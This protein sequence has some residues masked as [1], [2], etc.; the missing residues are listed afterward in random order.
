[1]LRLAVAVLLASPPPPPPPG[2][3]PPSV[4][5]EERSA[6]ASAPQPLQQGA[7]N[8]KNLRS[9]SVNHFTTYGAVGALGFGA[10][11][12][13]IVLITKSERSFNL[14]IDYYEEE[15]FVQQ[16]AGIAVAF[17]GGV[18]LTAGIAGLIATATARSARLELGKA[19]LRVDEGLQLRF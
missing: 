1:M 2:P 13:G 12:A 10:S 11:C 8:K 19:E 14:A 5:P 9:W 4:A 18:A 16:R 7:L 15:W 17:I 3:P 6:G